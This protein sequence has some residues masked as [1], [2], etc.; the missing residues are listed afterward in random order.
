MASTSVGD[1][2]R[3]HKAE[4]INQPYIMPDLSRGEAAVPKTV[5]G[6]F[7]SC[8]GHKESFKLIG[9][10]RSP[11]DTYSAVLDGSL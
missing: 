5:L 4:P 7:D 1:A 2:Q 6:G 8:I 3:L 11:I 9:S 10:T